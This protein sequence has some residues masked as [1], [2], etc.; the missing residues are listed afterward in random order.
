MTISR[1][2]AVLAAGVITLLFAVTGCMGGS[3]PTMS[4]PPSPSTSPMASP[5]PTAEPVDPLS[6][7]E[8]LVARPSELE[9]RAGGGTVVARLD[10]MSVPD[11]SV[12][13]LTKVFGSP[14][15]DDPYE[16]TNHTPPGVFHRWDQFVL[17]E[18]FYDEGR[19][20]AEGYDFV[21]W[22]RFAVYFDGP[23]ARGIVLSTSSGLQAGQ[24]WTSAEEDPGFDGDLWTCT[25]TSV[26]VAPTAVPST[27]T[28]P[29]RVNVIVVPTDD[30]TTV[31]WI[32]APEM[33]ADGCA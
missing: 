33:E 14:P 28:G 8:G 19:R 20:Q 30:R 27:W 24:P 10:Y 13:T 32:G 23:A 12:T 22:P 18:R 26:E 2:S 5:S 21:V 29:D 16:G 9:L 6:T 31:K 4:T 1:R 25:G 17:D 7:V 15:V 3:A 11:D